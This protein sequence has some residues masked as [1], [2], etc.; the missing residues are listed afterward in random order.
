GRSHEILFIQQSRALPYPRTASNQYRNIAPLRG[1]LLNS[2]L[3]DIV[4]IIHYV[5]CYEIEFRHQ[6][7]PGN[8]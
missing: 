4:N 2:V 7:N 6:S 3:Y 8:E 1:G 5:S